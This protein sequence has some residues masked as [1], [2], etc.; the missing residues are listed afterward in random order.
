MIL[1]LIPSID[2]LGG[3]IVRLQQGDR[4]RTTFYDLAPEAWIEQLVEA[5]AT[6]IHVVDLNG[7]FG[8]ALQ[9]Q[10]SSLPKRF[11]R[12]R[13][14]RGGGLRNRAILR[15]VLDE[16]FDAVVGTLA[17][18][19]PSALKG[20][21]HERVIVAL[22]IKGDHIVTHGW[23]ALSACTST[24]VFEA[25]LTLGFRRALVTDVSRD[26]TLMGPGL[27]AITWVAREGF[28][29]QASGGLRH[30]RD[31]MDLAAIPNVVGAISGKALLEG[32]IPLQDPGTRAALAGLPAGVL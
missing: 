19:Q 9:G 8:E 6:R 20:L 4:H 16:G 17:V 31:A 26:G 13:F 18:E 25:L 30:L 21:P 1:Q 22:D 3:R 10:I 32:H 15:Q 11:P 23:Q 29:V 5:G 27:E 14:Q 2:L 12:V 7:A 28:Y 24:D